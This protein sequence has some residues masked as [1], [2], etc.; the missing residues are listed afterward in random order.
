[1]KIEVYY[2]DR[3]PMA[4][5]EERDG[6]IVWNDTDEKSLDYRFVWAGSDRDLDFDYTQ[7]DKTLE[8]VFDYFNRQEPKKF[9]G[10][11]RSLSIG[12]VVCLED[13]CYLCQTVG[14]RKLENFQRKIERKNSSDE[15]AED[16]SAEPAV[17]IT[18]GD[19]V[20]YFPNIWFEDDF[21]DGTVIDDQGTVRF[22]DGF[23]VGERNEQDGIFLLSRDELEKMGVNYDEPNNQFTSRKE[24]M[25]REDIA[26]AV[27][28]NRM[29][30]AY[31]ERSGELVWLQKDDGD[32]EFADGERMKG[33]KLVGDKTLPLEVQAK[34]MTMLGQVA[35]YVA[36]HGLKKKA[37]S[38]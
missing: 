3:T 22:D 36:E 28:E 19:R 15:P 18:R 2:S 17:M 25:P 20:R 29:Q 31:E 14:W 27:A 7:D 34:M 23:D 8:S 10:A 32:V 35:Q 21:H 13:R 9:V 33:Y 37:E 1:M 16:E 38:E 6:K 4:S 11:F 26:L 5:F 30:L 24:T 12:D